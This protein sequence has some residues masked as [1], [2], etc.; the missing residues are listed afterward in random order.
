MLGMGPVFW[1]S[2][3][4]VIWW[5]VL[6]VILPLGV[7]SHEEEGTTPHPGSDPGAPPNPNLKKKFLTTTWVA[8][9]VAV[10]VFF[11]VELGWVP[12]PQ[13]RMWGA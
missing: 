6:F 12:L 13:L 4:L 1:G 8:A 11:V 5:M 10:V 7:R 3:Y 9:I 2:V